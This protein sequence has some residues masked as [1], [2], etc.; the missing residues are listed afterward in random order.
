MKKCCDTLLFLLIMSTI[1]S[2]E[3]RYRSYEE[4]TSA[5]KNLASDHSSIVKM[6]SLGKT[7]GGRDIWMLS[8]RNG[9]PEQARALLIV[10]GVDASCLAGSEMALSY[11]GHLAE[12]FETVDSISKLLSTTTMYIIPRVNP[13]ASE[14]YFEKPQRER[15][16][17]LRPTD[18]DH[19]G[20]IDEDD[21]EDLNGDGLITQMRVRDPHGEWLPDPSDPRLLKKADPTKGEHG[22]YSVHSEGVDNDKD[23]QWNEDGKGGVDF[24]RNFAH[25][26]EYFGAA[27]GP[28]PVSEN[29]SRAVADF[30]F[31][32]QNI[33][34]VFSFSSNDN[35]TVP[36]KADNKRGDESAPKPIASVL[37]EDEPYFG[38]IGKRFGEITALKNAPKPAKASGAFSEWVYY[39][40]GRWSFAARPWWA[41]ELKAPKDSSRKDKSASEVSPEF[42]ALKWYESNGASVF[43]PWKKFSHLDFPGREVEIGGLKPFVVHNPPA[44]SLQVYGRSFESFLTFLGMQLPSIAITNVKSESLKSGVFRITLDVVNNGYLP[45]NSAIGTKL[46]WSRDVYVTLDTVGGQ[47]IV[48]GKVRQRLE[49]IKGNGGYITL[50]WLVVGRAGTKIAVKAESP[51]AGAVEAM[52]TLQ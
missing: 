15:S 16:T 46:H 17:N 18:D 47:S 1:V 48:G 36:W 22:I 13:D 34:A 19:D 21:V 23:E 33:A 27:S 26:Y 11:A 32:H 7:L 43:V 31:V 2:G 4:M 24:N 3:V 40:V 44:E 51:M 25:T 50:T 35:L 20:A 49:P 28:Y 12:Q 30:I 6:K 52:V 10:G 5:M 45:T 9:D 14:S 8:L 38:F 29:E 41:P 42:T 37:P 39:D